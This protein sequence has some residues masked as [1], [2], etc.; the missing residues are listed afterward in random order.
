[1]NIKD[2]KIYDNSIEKDLNFIIDIVNSN[3]VEEVLEYIG[4]GA[5]ADVYRYK[6][7]AIKIFFD[8]NIINYD[9]EILSHLQNITCYPKLYAGN[10]NIMISEFIEG[11]TLN[12]LDSEDLSKCND[13][14][15]NLLFSDIK[16]TLKNHILTEDLNKNNIILS[17]NGLLKIIDVGYFELKNKHTETLLEYF[18]YYEVNDKKLLIQRLFPYHTDYILEKILDFITEKKSIDFIE[19]IA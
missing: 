11:K 9:V 3:K 10:N 13:N 18:N 16:T 5:E 4:S 6:N 7:Y 12:Q 1:M 14:C 17:S 8:Q 15:L 2:I 19:K